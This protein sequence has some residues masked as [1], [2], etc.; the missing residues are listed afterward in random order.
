MMAGGLW[1]EIRARSEI[2]RRSMEG[3][4]AVRTPLRSGIELGYGYRACSGPDGGERLDTEIHH[5]IKTL[6]QV[7]RS[8]SYHLYC[9]CFYRRSRRKLEALFPL[10][11]GNFRLSFITLPSFMASNRWLKR[12]Y[13]FFL[14]EVLLPARLKRDAVE[15]FVSTCPATPCLDERCVK[16]LHDL[17]H[18]VLAEPALYKSEADVMR[19]LFLNESFENAD[20][21]ITF[22]TAVRDLLVGQGIVRENRCSVIGAAA[23]DAEH[24]GEGCPPQEPVA[25]PVSRHGPILYVDVPGQDRWLETTERVLAECCRKLGREMSLLVA[26]S[27]G[28]VERVWTADGAGEVRSEGTAGAETMTARR[29]LE[30]AAGSRLVI[31]PGDAD[32]GCWFLMKA[33][34]MGCAVIVR[35]WPRGPA[36]LDGRLT[37]VQPGDWRGL[38]EKVLGMFTME[39]RPQRMV[40]SPGRYD[41]GAAPGKSAGVFLGA[42]R[43]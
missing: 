23:S 13:E 9:Y 8:S 18:I 21:V 3:V 31:Y 10:L 16:L 22:S 43:G 35:A 6:M 42:V 34:E 38:A 2:L 29:L 4:V 37:L 14:C 28:V 17:D 1:E 41:G 30:L 5:L 36:F 24:E 7:D 20:H 15:V 40:S 26:G 32:E 27:S 12:Y 19:R 25:E 33:S 11:P 39:G